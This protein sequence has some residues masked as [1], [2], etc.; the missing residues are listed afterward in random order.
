[1]VPGPCTTLSPLWWRTCTRTPSCDSSGCVCAHAVCYHWIHSALLDERVRSLRCAGGVALQA[2]TV[3]VKMW[4]DMESAESKAKFQHV[5]ATGQVRPIYPRPV[6]VIHK[7]LPVF[8]LQLEFVGGGWSMNDETTPVYQVR[9]SP[10]HV[11]RVTATLVHIASSR[12]VG[13]RGSSNGRPRVPP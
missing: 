10:V 8:C 11:C 6:F 4:W 13:H 7:M 12:T 3:W 9:A 5:V 1:M 2:E